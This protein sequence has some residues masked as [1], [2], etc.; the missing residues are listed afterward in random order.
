MK[1]TVTRLQ[2]DQRALLRLDNGLPA[3]LD[4]DDFPAGD[5]D[6][7]GGNRGVG[8]GLMHRWGFCEGF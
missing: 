8:G 3:Y 7:I 4:R 5:D 6:A 1:A 2:G